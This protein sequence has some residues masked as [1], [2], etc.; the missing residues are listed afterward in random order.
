MQ[1]R[2]APC[3]LSTILLLICGPVWAQQQDSTAMLS[4]GSLKEVKVTTPYERWQRDSARNRLL[5]R[6]ALGDAV[7]KPEVA[8][9]L[10]HGL[11][12]D[13]GVTWLAY[14]I[15][16]KQARA[17]RFKK[18]METHE[19]E[20]LISIRYHAPLVSR[21]TGLTDSAAHVF[22]RENPMSRSFFHSATEL[23]L[24]QWV[25]DRYREWQK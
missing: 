10:K 24:M 22:I 4:G 5:Y 16:G 20:Q 3:L 15:S 21:L 18:A 12:L 8:H 11:R 25:R 1:N 23:E 17:Q 13:G 14:R 6:K 9:P 7:F 2:L 19:N